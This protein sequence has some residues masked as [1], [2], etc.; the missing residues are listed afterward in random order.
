MWLQYGDDG[1]SLDRAKCFPGTLAGEVKTIAFHNRFL[2]YWIQISCDGNP[3]ARPLAS[4]KCVDRLLTTAA[5]P[6]NASEIP[7]EAGSPGDV[8]S[9][10]WRGPLLVVAYSAEGGLSEPALDVDAGVLGPVVEYLR[11]RREYDGPVFVEQPQE[12]YSQE[13][14]KLLLNKEE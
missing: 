10:T 4:N 8:G 14:W 5:L 11:L 6:A 12:R 9:E 13:K 7:H 3:R 2:P 1:R